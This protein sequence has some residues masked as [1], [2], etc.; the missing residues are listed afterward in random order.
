MNWDSTNLPEAWRRF[1]QHAELMFSGPLREKCEQDKCSYLLLWIG[2]KG[3]DV[4]NTWT[5]E[6]DEAK[7]LGTYYNKYTEYITPKSNPIYA[8]YRFHEKMQGNGETFEHFVTELKLLVK[9]CGYP[10]S[11]EMV[12]DRIVF[13][14]NSQRVREKLLSHGAELTLDKAIDIACSHE[15]AQAQL[16]DL[17]SD[18]VHAISRRSDHRWSYKSSEQKRTHTN[19]KGRPQEHTTPH[20]DRECDRCGGLHTTKDGTCPAKGKQCMKCKKLNH[21]AKVCKSKQHT[22]TNTYGR[23]TIHTVEED[24]D[25]GQ[26]ELFI[27]G[28]T[29]EHTGEHNE[30]AYA[31][32]EI[33]TVKVQFKN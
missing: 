12:R 24:T 14:T 22:H 20:R 16:K 18:A 2:E 27:D 32:I 13:A 17:N 4:F 28:L 5:L 25:D 6:G 10:N 31:D 26:A 3:R 29:T 8:R 19:S 33:G 9:D 11:D 7:K 30:R 21:F 15:L 23:K 1:K